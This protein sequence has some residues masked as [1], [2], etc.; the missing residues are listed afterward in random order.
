M[1]PQSYAVHCVYDNSPS[2]SPTV[3]YFMEVS[4]DPADE[5]CATLSGISCTNQFNS[6]TGPVIDNQFFVTWDASSVI[7]NDTYYPFVSASNGDHDYYCQLSP[8]SGT[9][10]HA[11]LTVRGI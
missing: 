11:F 7:T 2:P 3:K 4:P 6:T 10:E 9:Y 1:A 5:F 8:S